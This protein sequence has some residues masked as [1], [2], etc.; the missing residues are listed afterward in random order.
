MRFLLLFFCYFGTSLWSGAAAPA[1]PSLQP[2]QIARQFVAPAGWPLM[3]AYLSGEAATQAR[4]E[5]LGQQ[6]PGLLQRRC[7][8]LA[9]DSA[10]A[11]VA[12]ELRDSVS[13]DDLYLHFAKEQAIWK[14]RAI[15]R[16]SLT[17]LGPPMLQMFTGMSADEAARYDARHPEAP[18][19]FMVGNIR[20]WIG[21]DAALIE[22]FRRQQAGFQQAVELLRTHGY[23]AP[24]ASTNDSVATATERA[25]NADP[26]VQALLRPLFV[27]RV[28]RTV[29][30]CGTCLEFVIG[31]MADNTVGL[32]YQ[33]NPAAVPA[34]SPDRL[35]AL[36]PLGQGWY[37]FKTT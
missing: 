8:L 30:D 9:Q 13:R 35:I 17:H 34:M 12:V 11:V 37:L 15:R 23:L 24:A 21:S 26:A 16:L 27:H 19:A 14:L 29:L 3:R 32:L 28:G 10:T 4:R 31:G 18:H 2:L 36:R 33:P 22:H 25:A 7:E 6:I 1:P 5:T 20:L